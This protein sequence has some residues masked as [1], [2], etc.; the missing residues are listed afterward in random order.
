MVDGHRNEIQPDLSLSE[1]IGISWRYKWLVMAFVIVFMIIGMAMFYRQGPMFKVEGGSRALIEGDSHYLIQMNEHGLLDFTEHQLF[2]KYVR[3]LRDI[4]LFE[5]G[6]QEFDL[7]DRGEMAESEY[8]EALR[9]KAIGLLKGIDYLAS[10]EISTESGSP[11]RDMVLVTFEGSDEEIYSNFIAW[12]LNRSKL[13]LINSIMNDAE[14]NLNSMRDQN[15]LEIAKVEQDIE[16]AQ[17]EFFQNVE[18]RI[19]EL[20]LRK[21]I[22]VEEYF[23]SLEED[24]Y[25]LQQDINF[26]RKKD[27]TELEDDIWDMTDN[28][29]AIKARYKS[30][31]TDRI[32]YLNEQLQLAQ[33]LN[34]EGLVEWGNPNQ[35]L[36]SGSILTT[37]QQ[38]EQPYF[39]R[40]RI[41]IDQEIKELEQRT[42]DDSFIEGLR[43]LEYRLSRLKNERDIDGYIEGLR[44]KES[45]L[46]L[47]KGK[48]GRREY[49]EGLTELEYQIEELK[50]QKSEEFVP[51][52]RALQTSLA[53]LRNDLELDRK[54]KLV[55]SYKDNP[56]LISLVA[57]DIKNISS[58]SLNRSSLFFLVLSGL[59]GLIFSGLFVILKFVYV[60]NK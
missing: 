57:L 49:I 52:I 47:Y 21:N 45:L 23:K 17:V 44:Q 34:I 40:G 29:E 54:T 60:N 12:L 58:E 32:N 41:A 13:N 19:I 30:E 7:V 50:N 2:A 14:N 8:G 48:V 26:L 35:I 6:I 24:I 20:Q 31:K 1:I 9:K 37:I 56:A 25:V 55:D 22:L 3:Q 5:L 16:L 27:A 59:V 53:K 46:D 42:S 43:D 18:D 28:I 39:Y 4:E 11:S 10:G 36:E 33:S 38:G 51:D 15:Q